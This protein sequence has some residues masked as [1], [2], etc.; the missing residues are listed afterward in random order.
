MLDN[1][2]MVTAADEFQ[3]FVPSVETGLDATEPIRRAV[4]RGTRPRRLRSSY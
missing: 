2:Q 3:A 1:V 4:L